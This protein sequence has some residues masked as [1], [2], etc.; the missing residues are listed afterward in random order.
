MALKSEYSRLTE[1]VAD[2]LFGAS[3]AGLPVYCLADT[4]TRSAIL[5]RAKITDE[6]DEAF[7]RI[8]R[9][10]LYLDE[11][12]FTPFQWHIERTRRQA[13]QFP[14]AP[15]ALPLL[16]VLASAAEAMQAD[17]DHAAHN[18][19]DRLHALLRTPEP[20]RSRVESDYRRSAGELWGAL[21]RWLETWEGE[22]GI[23]TAYAVGGHAYVGLPMSQAVVRQHD[24]EGL[25]DFFALEGF[26]PG[27]RVAPSDMAE[28]LEPYAAK[29]PSPL[30]AHL[31]GLWS[32]ATARDRIV[33][34]ACLELEAWDGSGVS[35]AVPGRRSGSTSLLAFLRTFPRKRIEF[36]LAIPYRSDS[37]N[38][39]RFLSEAG[40]TE[41]ST[42]AGPGGSTRLSTVQLVDAES[43]ISGRITGEFGEAGHQPVS[44]DPRRVT[45]LRWDAL[46]GAYVEVECVALGD[47]VLVLAR[48]EARPRVEAHLHAHARPGWSEIVALPGLPEN[49]IAYERVQI[50]AVPTGT[51]HFDLL[52]LTPRA[53]TSLTIQGGFRLPGLLRKW[54]SLAPPE[55][56]AVAADAERVTLRAYD[57]TGV[58]ESKLMAET[59]SV[60][61]VAVLPL[62]GEELS[63]GEYLAALYVND[64]TRPAS[65][66]LIRLRS[67]STPQFSVA[68]DD[69]RLV[70]APESSATWA[71]SAGP[72]GW[73]S[74]VNGARTLGLSAAADVPSTS[75]TEFAPRAARPKPPRPARLSVGVPVGEDSCL[76]TGKHR[77]QLP[78]AP[79]PGER[80]SRTIVGECT[81]C[82]TIRRGAGTASAARRRE[83]ATKT[84][85]VV[86]DLPSVTD[87][88]EQDLRT[89]VDA[90]N[91]V[92]HGAFS[93]LE[94]VA[95]QIE[96]SGLLADSLSRRLEVLGHIDIARDDRLRATDWAVNS[97]ALVPVGH[98]AYVLIGAHSDTLVRKL[99]RALAPDAT[100]TESL[101]A[102]IPRIEV[103]GSLSTHKLA[104]L[105]VA[106][107]GASPSAEIA[108]AL[109]PLSSIAEFLTR[110]AVPKY[111]SADSW[112][113]ASAS[114]ISTDSLAAVGAYRL[115]DFGSTYVVRSEKDLEDGTLGLG[116]AQL[117]KHIANLWAEDPLVRYHSKTR[118]VVV[119]LGADLPALYGRAL[120]LCSG[121]APV[122]YEKSR[123]LQYPAIPRDVADTVFSRMTQ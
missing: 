121:R 16:V 17:S 75:I 12:K 100:V 4:D 15:V 78:P 87:T 18:Y 90:L 6:G 25:R 77:T 111:R 109:P 22:R 85:Q 68:D 82:G 29:T 115:R 89:A 116:N 71:L 117:V 120:S 52:P 19:Y 47:E 113:T 94:R 73:P 58:D 26:A 5:A 11:L 43:L 24:R 7:L 70:Y 76:I 123:L 50:V 42:V 40:E 13:G 106:V 105:E 38:V 39:V 118:S 49:W 67:A 93:V 108:S 81:T 3:Q 74:H 60:G 104:D 35:Q 48:K 33:D 107:L 41:I 14:D 122:E 88:S 8:V 72:A 21:N 66:A 20:I 80:A 56:F 27:Q 64:S 114:W 103:S 45:P 31:V 32:N 23:P 2:E 83:T 51:A 36:N 62:A 91:H 99:R 101:D 30:S 55:I 1:A 46:Q 69:I 86:L 92:G 119:P 61:A 110:I 112:D 97:A 9:S 84:M 28:A 96:G 54:S 59:S 63:D 95:A 53:R 79:L 65:T 98:H 44:R 10:T 37:P 57:G 34:A 102:G